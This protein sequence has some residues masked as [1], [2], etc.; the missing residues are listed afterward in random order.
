MKHIIIITFLFFSLSHIVAQDIIYLRDG[1]EIEAQIL[2]IGTSSISYKKYSNIEGPTYVIELDK[3]FMILYENGEKDVFK[4]KEESTNNNQFATKTTLKKEKREERVLYFGFNMAGGLAKLRGTEYYAKTGYK[5]GFDCYVDFGNRLGLLT[6][7]QYTIYP[8]AG[9]YLNTFTNQ[10]IKYYGNFQ[11]LGIPILLTINRTNS[12]NFFIETGISVNFLFDDQLSSRALVVDYIYNRDYSLAFELSAN[13]V[14]NL[15]KNTSLSFGLC[16][17]YGLTDIYYYTNEF[18]T[19]K[20]F[21][22][23]PRIAFLM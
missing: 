21:F 2:E 22:L 11:S 12:S 6:G 16:M 15:S 19:S 5:T 14:M 1:T 8:I 4:L 17:H 23:Y 9:H 7:V 20:S 10:N 13:K 3:L 18:K